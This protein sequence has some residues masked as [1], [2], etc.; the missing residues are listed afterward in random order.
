[1]AARLV[2]P[3]PGG[4][5]RPDPREPEPLKIGD[6]VW[7]VRS[8]YK[9]TDEYEDRVVTAGRR[10]ATLEKTNYSEL[11][12][13]RMTLQLK[14]GYGLAVWRSHEEKREREVLEATWS[15]LAA[16]FRNRYNRPEE[17]TIDQLNAAMTAL[18]IETK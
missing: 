11:K 18:G 3:A 2:T 13:D 7:V 10:W 17:L 6:T 16:W 1:M 9:G 5:P 15:R 14:N 12:V 4:P 8:I